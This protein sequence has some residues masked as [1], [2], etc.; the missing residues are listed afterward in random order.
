MGTVT[1][2]FSFCDD[3]ASWLIRQYDHGQW[4]HVDAVLADGS[5]LG[6][7]S[8]EVGGKPSGVQIRPAGYINFNGTK[9]LLIP[10]ADEVETVFYS[11][12]MSQI[13]KPYDRTA[14][15]GF[16]FERDWRQTD[17][18]F[19]SEGITWSAEQAKLFPYMLAMPSSKVTP[20][21]L[22]L[23]CSVLADVTH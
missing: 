23:A 22:Y 13:G 3:P 14:I 16:V 11:V 6:S 18:W 20:S 10:C 8:D 19:C 2:Q 15:M 4:S 21:G 17:A 5:L 12:W 9:K 1:V 7:R